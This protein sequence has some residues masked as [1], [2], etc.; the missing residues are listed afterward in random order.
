MLCFCVGVHKDIANTSARYFVGRTIIMHKCCQSKN[1]KRWRWQN[2]VQ[3]SSASGSEIAPLVHLRC[4]T[5]G[6]KSTYGQPF[7]AG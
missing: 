6:T 7:L 3:R 1:L 4:G 2:S 5:R